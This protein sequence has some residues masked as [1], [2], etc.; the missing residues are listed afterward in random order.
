[1]ANQGM[2]ICM[3]LH[4]I[5]VVNW[6]CVFFLPNQNFNLESTLFQSWSSALKW[7]WSNV[8]NET[9]SDV[10]FSTL[11]NVDTTSKQRCCN[12]VN[13]LISFFSFMRKHFMQYNK[14][15]LLTVI[16]VVLHVAN[17]GDIRRSLKYCSLNT[18]KHTLK[19]VN[20][21]N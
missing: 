16:H 6:C 3:N 10:G 1:M 19:N 18:S 15:Q 4:L 13:G 5:C 21:W 20:I 11:H 8:E 2:K 14:I 17:K 9:K 12:F 7:R